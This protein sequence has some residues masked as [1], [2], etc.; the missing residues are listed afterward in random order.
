[1]FQL[2]PYQQ[3]AVNAVISWLKKSIEPCLVEAATGA[4]KSLIVSSIAKWVKDN[5]GKRVLCLAPSKELTEQNHEKYLAYGE[6]ASF[7]SASLGK[8]LRHNV[9]FGTP[10]TVLNSI[11]Q[12][13][14][15]NFSAVIIDECHQ[16]TP[17]IKT[18]IEKLKETNSKL[19]AVGLSATPYRLND[20]YIYA[21][22]EEGNPV[23]EDQTKDPYFNTLV[24][25][26]TAP[27]LIAQGYLT[28]PHAD[29]DHVA[30]YDTSCIKR[31][32]QAE[33][34]KA[35][36]G[37]GRKTAEIIAD[38]VSHAQGRMGVMI[39]AATIAHAE[40]CMESLPQENSQIITGKTPKGEREKIINDYKQQRFKYLVNVA[41]LTTGFDAPHVDCV[42]VLR[43]TESASL[44][45][46][47]IG[48]GMRIHPNKY[49][50]L[51]LDYAENIER[52]Q[53]EDDLFMPQIK[54]KRK[55]KGEPMD[56]KCPL[57][58][59]INEF[60]M[61]PNPEEFKIDEDGDF[62]DLAGNKIL[63]DDMPLPAHYGRR[64]F[65]QNIIKGESNRCEHRWS[66]KECHECDH[67]NDIAARFCEKCKMELVDP[68]EKL[69]LDFHRMKADPT[70]ISTDYVR[71]FDIQKW[72]GKSGNL[73]IK[74]SYVTDYA[75]FDV[76]YNPESA[77]SRIRGTYEDFSKAYFNGRVAPDTNTF[78]EYRN[79]G[80]APET[81]TYK[82]NKGTKYF[83]VFAHNNPV[84]KEP[85]V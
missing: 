65:G 38:V 27:Y 20:G 43:A 70:Q 54:A 58:S 6:N 83:D 3:D 52:H 46:Q 21:Y 73:M 9:V 80:K 22:D 34:E 14:R 16:I 78:F 33:Y 68:N 62:N 31:H 29:P 77:S 10:K 4:G 35:F 72:S 71:S 53:L 82:R 85:D 23:P 81:I 8:S 24:Y 75:K 7:F 59:A 17:T 50:C 13:Q 64:C 48:R 41:V 28:Q 60:S 19:R 25:R 74:A 30:S 26:I 45:Q 51:V 32:T 12:I 47:I 49:D 84:D 18:I 56:I 67:Q 1:M 5:T 44:L 37:K 79:K 69:R 63:V 15:G 61:R 40:E 55:K 57:C 11:Q 76:W 66:V 36:E 42:A 2:R 39:F